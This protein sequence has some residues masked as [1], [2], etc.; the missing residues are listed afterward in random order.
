[1]P[2]G[3]LDSKLPC[4]DRKGK[5]ISALFTK[6]EQ[7]EI[8]RALKM[9]D[10]PDLSSIIEFRPEGPLP[11]SGLMAVLDGFGLDGTVPSAREDRPAVL[12][13]YVAAPAPVDTG[14]KRSPD[15]DLAFPRLPRRRKRGRRRRRLIRRS[16][17]KS[18]K[19][20][21]VRTIVPRTHLPDDDL[22]F[23]ASYLDA[24]CQRQAANDCMDALVVKYDAELKASFVCLGKAQEEAGR[25]T[26][27]VGV[28]EASLGK[29][30]V[31]RDEA[32]RR[33]K[34][35]SMHAEDILSN[36]T[37]V[38]VDPHGSNVGLIGVE[39]VAGLQTSEHAQEGRSGGSVGAPSVGLGKGASEGNGKDSTAV[40]SDNMEEEEEISGFDSGDEKGL[41]ESDKARPMGEYAELQVSTTGASRPSPGQEGAQGAD[42]AVPK[43]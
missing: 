17:R 16:R 33:A 6:A 23:R 22:V 7:Q 41:L 15:G 27:R 38:G 42:P 18:S 36:E 32:T 26:E 21:I 30:V 10:L 40:I 11:A 37:P 14:R 12:P 29:A 39:A 31:K 8:T 3:D 34:I 25:G 13:A 4:P 1:M 28:L 5:K 24:V 43:E 9:R 20:S 2:A 19:R 35:S